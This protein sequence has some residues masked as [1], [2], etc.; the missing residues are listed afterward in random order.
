MISTISEFGLGRFI[1]SFPSG[2]MTLVGE[3]G[4]NLSGG[5]KQ[6]LAFLR[7]LINKP[8]ILIIDEGTS[9]M[10]RGT[11]GIIMNIIGKLKSETGIL[12]ISHR[13][14]LIKELSDYIYV[15]EDRVITKEGA[16]VDLIKTENIY[17]RFWN[18]F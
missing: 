4:I 8:D 15:I 14:H 2:L 17:R 12:L 18:D 10:D 3:D 13:L 6:L 16:H 7:V 1:E 11:E 5:Q 9:N